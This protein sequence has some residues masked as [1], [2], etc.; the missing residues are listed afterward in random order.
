MWIGADKFLDVDYG[1][2]LNEPAVE[3]ARILIE[4]GKGAFALC[5]FVT[6]GGPYLLVLLNHKQ[7]LIYLGSEATEG[8]LKLA[9]QVRTD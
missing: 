7:F 1:H 6:G 8:V 5:Y 3:L 2:F 9:R 4:S